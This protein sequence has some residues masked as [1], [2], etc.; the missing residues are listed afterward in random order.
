MDENKTKTMQ[1]KEFLDFCYQGRHYMSL[2]WSLDW[3]TQIEPNVWYVPFTIPLEQ[4]DLTYGDM[5]LKTLVN[6]DGRLVDKSLLPLMPTPTDQADEADLDDGCSPDVPTSGS[7]G[8]C[9]C[10]QS[11]DCPAE[12]SAD[13]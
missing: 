13:C 8:R 1:N 9:D 2:D 12:A 7:Q 3:A 5:P 10:H 6:V 4:V 11:T